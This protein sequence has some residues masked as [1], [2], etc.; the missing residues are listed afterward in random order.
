MNRWFA[1]DGYL[2]TVFVKIRDLAVLNICFLLSCIPV[3]T[4]GAALTALYSVNLRMVRGE[5]GRV[6]ADYWKAFRDNFRQGTRIWLLLL[7]LTALF[8][9]DFWALNQLSGVASF[10]LKILLGVLCFA[11]LAAAQYVFA[12][13]ARFSDSFGVI[14]K[15]SL[16]ICG[17]NL[18]PTASLLCMVFLALFVSFYSLEVFL[19]AVYIWLVLGFSTLNHLRSFLLRRV[20]AQYESD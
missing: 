5:E 10:V 6:F 17:A 12:Y 11:V 7:A 3:V 9:V 2:Q 18:L 16:M 8:A 4:I 20:F 19:R 1:P 15:N 13:A 14:L